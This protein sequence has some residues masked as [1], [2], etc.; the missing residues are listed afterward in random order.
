MS[1]ICMYDYFHVLVYYQTKKGIM[2]QMNTND[3]RYMY[4]KE[5]KETLLLE[6]KNF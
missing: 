3:D 4:F 1:F 2:L 5:K 6:D